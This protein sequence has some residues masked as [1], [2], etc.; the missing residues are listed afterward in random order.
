MGDAGLGAGG[1]F[2]GGEMHGGADAGVG[3][4]TA[5]V[6]GHGGVDFGVGRLGCFRQKRSGTHDLTGLA[7]AALGHIDFVPSGLDGGSAFRIEAFDGGDVASSERGD[8]QLAG[9]NG[10]TVEVNGACSAESH[11]AT[12]FGANEVKAIPQN[13]EQRSIRG[14]FNGVSGAVYF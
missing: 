3:A 8:G 2:F 1:R 13:P 10:L 5:E 9:P 14:G 12:V 7:V 6:T 11:A 4:A